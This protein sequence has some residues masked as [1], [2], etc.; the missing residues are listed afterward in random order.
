M[1][2]KG[3]ENNEGGCVRR[4]KWDCVLIEEILFVSFI[5]SNDRGV[6]EGSGGDRE[7]RGKWN[8][9]QSV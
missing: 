2:I 5:E 1:S 7:R 6:G 4:G 9:V 8:R 3:A